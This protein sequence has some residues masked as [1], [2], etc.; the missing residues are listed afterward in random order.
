[1]YT[2]NLDKKELKELIDAVYGSLAYYRE[3]YEHYDDEDSKRNL[4]M[5]ENL[6]HK[7]KTALEKNQ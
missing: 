4:R 6:L 5:C 1:M 3:E 7:L 2:V